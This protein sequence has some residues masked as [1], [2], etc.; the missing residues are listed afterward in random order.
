MNTNTYP[1]HITN[2][3][4]LV[5]R[6]TEHS[7]YTKARNL[8]DWLFLKYDMSYKSFRN[9]SKKR[10]DEMRLEYEQDTGKKVRVNRTGDYED[11][12]E[13]EI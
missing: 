6:K 12:W 3:S 7:D 1:P 9:K 13:E 2:P 10:R 5:R 8:T 4:K 11:E